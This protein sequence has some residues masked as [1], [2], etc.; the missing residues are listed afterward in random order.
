[1]SR[2]GSNTTGEGF[3]NRCWCGNGGGTLVATFIASACR[4]ARD[5]EFGRAT[6]RWGEWMLK[7]R[8]LLKISGIQMTKPTTIIEKSIDLYIPTGNHTLTR[9]I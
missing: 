1:M 8:K 2:M 6:L 5:V 3:A 4:S 9:P 7:V